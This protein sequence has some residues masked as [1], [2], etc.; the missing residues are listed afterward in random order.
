MWLN[1]W[2]SKITKCLWS[3]VRSNNHSWLIIQTLHN[4]LRCAT[5]VGT[6]NLIWQSFW[7]TSMDQCSTEGAPKPGQTH[8]VQDAPQYNCWGFFLSSGK[9]N[10]TSAC[11]GRPLQC[12][13]GTK[14]DVV[15]GL[16]ACC[17]SFGCRV[18]HITRV[19]RGLRVPCYSVQCTVRSTKEAEPIHH[20][21]MH[22]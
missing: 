20:K 19:S 13:P 12:C 16:R 11:E 22:L 14:T 10:H 15:P 7:A 1:F 5:A 2:L 17:V 4:L 3:E 8:V 9:H 21:V 18:K 6:S